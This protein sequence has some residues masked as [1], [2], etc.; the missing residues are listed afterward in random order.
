MPSR[1]REVVG[2]SLA[3]GCAGGT[4]A[5]DGLPPLL[6]DP[7]LLGA[8]PKPRTVVA[9]AAPAKPAVP[10][11]AAPPR[12][13]AVV[14]A[15][16]QPEPAPQV[17]QAELPARPQPV[18]PKLPAAAEAVRPD[19]LAPD[20]AKPPVAQPAAPEP[21]QPMAPPVVAERPLL[22]P[23]YSAHAAAG[24]LPEPALKATPGLAELGRGGSE[25]HPVFISADRLRGRSDVETVAEGNVE[26]RRVGSTLTADRLTYWPVEDEMEAVGQVRLTR[27]ED[28]ITGPRLRMK[29]EENLG[30]FE[31]PQYSLK[32]TPFSAAAPT[33]DGLQPRREPVTGTGEASRI[34]FEGEG[35][36][37]LTSATYSTCSPSRRDW[38]AQADEISLDYNSERGEAADATVYFKDTPI[39]YSPWLSFS[40][41]N[42]RKSGLLTPTFGSTSNNGFELTLPWY[43]NIAPNM[44]ATISPRMMTK[45]GAQLNTELR[46]L[47][48]NYQGQARVEYL[49][50]DRIARR[51]RSGYSI[52][53][54]Q[55][56]GRGFTGAL[57]LNGV[58][59]DSYFSDLSSRVSVVTQTNLLR[60]GNLTYSAGWW[61]AT[62]MA[63][64]YQTLQDPSLP[65]VTE[66]YAR[67]PQLTVSAL[68]PDLPAG[69]AFSMAGEYVDFRHPTQVIGKRT[70]LY[71]Q[72]SLPL[73]TAA[74]YVTPKIGIHNTSYQ[75]ERQALGTPS[76]LDRQ[77][78]IYSV[79]TGV[80]FERSV[81]WFDRSLLQTLEPRLYYLY[82]ESRDQSKIPVFD[83]GLAD[84]NFAQIFA[85]NRYGGSDRFGDANQLTAV[86]TSRLIDP[87]TGGELM[88]AMLG[89]RFYF[90]TQHVTLPAIGTT[91]A[92][93]ARSD[94]KT[95]LLAAFSGQ[96]LP[97]TYLDTA[98][99]YSPSFART[100]R[101]NLGGRYQPESGKVLNA[102]YRFARDQLGQIDVSGQWPLTGG[103]HGVGRYNY[104]IKESRT[105]ETIGGVEYDG[106]C[107]VG[108]FVVQRLATQ[109]AKATTAIFFQL[110]LNGFSRIGSN[111]LELLKRNVPG[112]GVINQPTADPVFAA[113]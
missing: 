96:V 97:R 81:D 27:D 8:P 35:L 26:M 3:V 54:T 33:A 9:P 69:L 36:Y 29:I 83:A 22:P 111:P 32:R 1:F 87:A 91:P 106:G 95:D 28:V 90:T 52:T 47:D 61:G 100:E 98:W 58:S 15:P 71:P 85:E 80:T 24:E 64:R 5:A 104:S 18:A 38:Y 109:T 65:V 2:L 41:N 56:L 6:V 72:L 82:V 45:R 107:W 89:Q 112:Y 10:V 53:H 63:Q 17:R 60:Q 77:L 19:V 74:F 113:N 84:F 50:D 70:I 25:V 12:A 110:E 68:R 73:Q 88:R 105:V 55:N 44:D 86:V 16:R 93:V 99:Q 7:A 59:D 94:R 43:W 102:G 79:D 21:S 92:E 13:P 75:L 30:V 48:Y 67:L 51:S 37:R 103:W 76:R 66:P 62:L 46:Y 11:I 49:P 78:P 39:L 31:Q 4:I 108:R 40:L 23:L 42:Q 34:D 14:E 57:N 101:F 20:A